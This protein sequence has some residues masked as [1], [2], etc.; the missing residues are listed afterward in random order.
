MLIALC[1]NYENIHLR[2]DISKIN[3]NAIIA[4]ASSKN[5]KGAIEQPELE[6]DIILRLS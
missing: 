6:S 2:I 5:K 4:M 1:C 3:L